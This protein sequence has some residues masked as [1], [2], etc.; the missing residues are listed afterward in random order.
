MNKMKPI[1][2]KKK[3][4]KVKKWERICLECKKPFQPK[5]SK[6]RLCSPECEKTRTNRRK[7]EYNKTPRGQLT[8]FKNSTKANLKKMSTDFLFK[9]A[10]QC[11]IKL[12][13]ID[14]ILKTRG[15]SLELVCE[16]SDEDEK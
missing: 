10:N 2:Y 6:K 9:R 12:E 16:E 4:I 8:L 5:P 7:R 14:E 3:D 11:V 1:W 15:T 13:L